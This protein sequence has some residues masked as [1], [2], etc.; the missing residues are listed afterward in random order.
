MMA[1]RRLLSGWLIVNKN[2]RNIWIAFLYVPE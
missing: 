2:K 1:C